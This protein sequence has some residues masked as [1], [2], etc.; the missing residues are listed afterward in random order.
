MGG[1]VLYVCC[2]KIGHC[3]LQARKSPWHKDMVYL[4]SVLARVLILLLLSPSLHA[5]IP[6]LQLLNSLSKNPDADCKY[7]LYF[8][9]GKRKVDYILVYHYKRSSA[10]RTLARRV[11]HNDSSTRNTKQDQ[12][13]PGKGVQLEM[14]E[15]E[16]HVDCHEDDKRF[17]REEY[18]GNLVEAGLE[19]EHDEDVRSHFKQLKRRITGGWILGDA[20]PVLWTW[21][22]SRL[23]KLSSFRI[24]FQFWQCHP[25]PP[26]SFASQGWPAVLL[27][28][29]RAEVSY[30][31][32]PGLVAHPQSQHSL[33]MCCV[34]RSEA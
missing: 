12:P 21:L 14:G 6:C 23:H 26:F 25:Y 28:P 9:D 22:W 1:F 7:G 31:P 33:L 11:H 24:W 3:V 5:P 20:K 29:Q 27:M 2:L 4:L 10:G 15:G 13:L 8:R 30:F 18:E 16:P 17:R 32:W 34:S 19:L